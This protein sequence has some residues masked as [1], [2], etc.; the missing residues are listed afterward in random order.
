MSEVEAKELFIMGLESL[1]NKETSAALDYLEKAVNLVR[2]PLYCSYLAI[3]LAKEKGEF[4]RAVSLCKEAIKND[5]KNSSHFLNLGRIQLLANQKKDAI[6]VF[7]IG[8]RCGDNRHIKAELNKFGMRRLPPIPF[9]VR[10]NPINK[11]LGK[12]TYKLGFR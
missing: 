2:D 5:P 4:R 1:K 8:L 3:C 9:L 7:H 10:E 12:L 11:F 6:R